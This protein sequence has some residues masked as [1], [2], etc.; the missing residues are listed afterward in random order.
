MDGWVQCGAGG[1]ECVQQDVQLADLGRETPPHG[2]F[3]TIELRAEKTAA[4]AS[5]LTCD[6]APRVAR[7]ALPI[8]DPYAADDP[9][10]LS[11]TPFRT[12]RGIG[13][14][15]YLANKLGAHTG[16][17][18]AEGTEETVFYLTFGSSWN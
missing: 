15:Y 11:A 10:D 18:I 3:C 6:H 14:R 9:G 12:T 13:L 1:R 8:V 4:K 16:F 2:D 7:S 5:L 17:D